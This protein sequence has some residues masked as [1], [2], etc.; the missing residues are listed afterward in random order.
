MDPFA[1]ALDAL[2]SAPGSAA[3]IFA[4]GDGSPAIN[5]RIIVRQSDTRTYFAKTND[6][7]ATRLIEVRRAEASLPVHGDV[8]IAGVEIF[9]VAGS[10]Y[11]DVEGQ[12]WLCEVPILDHAVTLMSQQRVRDSGG[13][14]TEK[15][16][17]YADNVP[18]AVQF[19]PGAE[20]VVDAQNAAWTSAIFRIAYS[21]NV[22]AL[23]SKDQ[24]L[25][26]DQPFDIISVAEIGEMAGLEI[27]GTRIAD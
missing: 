4:P 20:N 8:F 19:A 25:Y 14:W 16:A 17:P 12:T 15:F 6:A 21:D 7:F 13:D 1:A 9:Q 11:L 10:P 2:F 5:V 22:A 27:H 18:A 3:A 26:R 23:K 24:L